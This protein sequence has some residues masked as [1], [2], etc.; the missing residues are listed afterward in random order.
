MV[1]EKAREVLPGSLPDIALHDINKQ[2]PT[3]EVVLA[4]VPNRSGKPETAEFTYL[5]NIPLPGRASL[6]GGGLPGEPILPLVLKEPLG[7]RA[8]MLEMERIGF[9][10]LVDEA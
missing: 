4:Q 6:V 5:L 10:P 8:Q 7:E 9:A 3:S 2:P 1:I